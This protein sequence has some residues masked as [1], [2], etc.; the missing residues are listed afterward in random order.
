MS[1]IVL[2][3][4]S[5]RINLSKTAPNALS[6]IAVGLG[7]DPITKKGFLGRTVQESVDLDA[8]CLMF[9]ANLDMVD[10]VWFRQLKSGC[11]N[12]QHSGDNRT[13]DG[14][15]DDETITLN[16]AQ[17]PAQIQHLVFTVHS[18]TG[19]TFDKIETA[20]C[21]VLDQNGQELC[22]YPL[23]QKGS[24]TGIIIASLSRKNGEWE[25]TAHGEM[26]SGRTLKDAVPLA[27]Q[28]LR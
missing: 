7:W 25:F 11:G 20:S 9:N 21:R 12:V 19:H 16:L 1:S 10:Q 24:H 17:L 3:K 4:S 27:Q 26:C 18:F 8:S 15:G 22:K 28:L 6:K 5:P 13:G 23:S 14:D 2:T